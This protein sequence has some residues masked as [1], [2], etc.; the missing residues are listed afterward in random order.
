MAQLQ[1]EVRSLR[2]LVAAADEAQRPRGG[3]RMVLASVIIAAGALLTTMGVM[4]VW[5]GV[6]DPLSLQS[7]SVDALEHTA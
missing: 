1:L 3:P 5:T 6:P 2:A 7:C 4:A